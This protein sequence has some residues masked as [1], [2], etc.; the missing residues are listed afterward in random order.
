MEVPFEIG[1]GQ[2]TLVL[3]PVISGKDVYLELAEPVPVVLMFNNGRFLAENRE[4]NIEGV[5][6]QWDDALKMFMDFFFKR[7]MT[8]VSSDL[9]KLDPNDR[10][11]WDTI[12][13]LIPDWQSQLEGFHKIT[14]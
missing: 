13:M 11:Q 7:F 10:K 8:F 5:G 4:M 14:E 12:R 9:E 3:M 1:S 6:E 2:S